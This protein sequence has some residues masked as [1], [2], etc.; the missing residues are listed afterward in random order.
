MKIILLS[1]SIL[2]FELSFGQSSSFKLFLI[3]DTG[4][5]VKLQ[6]TMLHF[7]DT[8]S[9]YPNSAAVFLGDNCYKGFRKG[10]D[11]SKVTIDVLG[12]QLNGLKNS[13]Y[14]GSVYFVPGNHEWWNVT[15]KMKKGKRNLKMNE[16]F[17]ESKLS[18]NQFIRNKANPFMPRNGNPIAAVDLNDN[19]L[20]LI[21]LDT[22]WLL[23]QK[24]E[25]EKEKVYSQLDSM[26]ENA[27]SRKQKLLVA[28]H[29]PIYTVGKHSK[30][31]SWQFP[32][33]WK[34][35]DIYHPIYNDMRG[36]IKK[37]LSQKNYPIIYAGGHDHALEYFRKDSVQYIV[38]GA[39]SKSGQYS[40]KKN[41]DFN[42]VS[43]DC[44][45]NQIAK[46]SEGY[47]EVEYT[48]NNVSINAVLY[49]LCKQVIK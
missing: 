48:G 14:Q 19:Q 41:L 27:I 18:K 37:I 45:Q 8:I 3:G 36:R 49:K 47:F 21:F 44:L 26:L 9:L 10:F 15:K 7:L 25:N 4:E 46:V 29:H 6:S 5:D 17:I 30:K 31:R 42:P 38:S 32:R 11:S 23:I 16:S 35:Q 34:G 22:Q 1:I 24:N 33:V 43:D 20:K 39:G 13:K 2:L 12:A 40:K 28:A